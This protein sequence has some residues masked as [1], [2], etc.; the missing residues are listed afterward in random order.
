MIKKNVRRR[1]IY[2]SME[3]FYLTKSNFLFE[4]KNSFL[5][6]YE[7]N[8]I[9]IFSTATLL[10]IV[11]FVKIVLLFIKIFNFEN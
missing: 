5:F 3:M 1:I 9:F 10:L 6:S 7:T 2:K 4:S 11:L 8:I